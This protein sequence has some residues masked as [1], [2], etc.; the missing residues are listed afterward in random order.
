M[1]KMTKIK[2]R[3]R[4]DK[5]ASDVKSAKEKQKRQNYSKEKV[6]EG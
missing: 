3:K 1:R 6:N 5:R 2:E 4:K